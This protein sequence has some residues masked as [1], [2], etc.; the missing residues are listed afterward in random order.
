MLALPGLLGVVEPS[1]TVGF[2]NM[3]FW[4]GLGFKD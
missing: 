4:L 1:R 3:Y 2:I